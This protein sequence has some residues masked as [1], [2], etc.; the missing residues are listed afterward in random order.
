MTFKKSFKNEKKTPSGG[1]SKVLQIALSSLGR[2]FLFELFFILSL[3]GPSTVIYFGP[4]LFNF[5]QPGFTL[6]AFQGVPGSDPKFKL[7]SSDSVDVL[8]NGFS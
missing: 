2:P 8:S 7:S 1:T 6:S 5:K 4:D 3:S